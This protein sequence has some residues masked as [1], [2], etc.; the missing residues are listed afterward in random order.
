[1]KKSLLI[2]LSLLWGFL[3]INEARAISFTLDASYSD[4]ML[5]GYP[6]SGFQDT[7]FYIQL[8]DMLVMS[9][10]GISCHIADVVCFGPDGN[11]E[12]PPPDITWTFLAPTL[13]HGSLVGRI[14][15]G[16]PF[17]VGVD[18]SQVMNE[19]GTL[20]LGFNDSRTDDNS[21]F[22]SV[23]IN[24]VPE[25]ATILL[26]GSGFVGIAILIRGR[27]KNECAE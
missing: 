24:V 22:F 8:G 25:P 12:P 27:S 26:L 4:R 11:G 17:F 9:A 7:G 18:F 20:F 1:M 19:T 23:D 15:G 5:L 3:F 10:S 16:D 21:G 6:H 14:E 13:S 2:L